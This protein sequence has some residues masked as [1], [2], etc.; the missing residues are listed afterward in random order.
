MSYS[1][2]PVK[3]SLKPKR[4]DFTAT[5]ADLKETLKAVV[6]LGPTPR[7][8]WN[9]RFTDIYT[10][11]VAYPDPLAEKLYQ[12]TKQFLEDHVQFLL[13]QVKECNEEQL[14]TTYY[15]LWLQYSQGVNYLNMLYL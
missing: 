6:M 13:V 7:A 2:I 5:W 11:C 15:S 9:D 12:E 4:V 1:R 14:L 3:M 10:L 8:V